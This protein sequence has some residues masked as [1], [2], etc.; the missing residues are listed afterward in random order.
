MPRPYTLEI[1]R[2]Y[3]F[4]NPED[5]PE[6]YHDR[7]KRLRVGYSF[8]YEFP[9][10]TESDIRDHLMSVFNVSRVKAY[11]DI[12]LIKILLGDIKNPG[13][14]WIRYQVNAMLDAAYNQALK[15]N[16]SKAMTLAAT[17]KGKLNMLHL[18][19]AEPVPFDEI[20]PQQ[21]EPTDDPT[22]LGLK[23]D[24]DIREKKRKMLEKYMDDIEIVDVP[25]DEMVKDGNE[26]E[27]EDLL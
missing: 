14:E 11:D 10:K 1:Y 20:V 25:Y 6:T 19:D 13:K 12:N 21:F 9:T 15:D 26:G 23:K 2:K 22:P 27:E 18:P 17:A 8:W 4:S 5:I 3:L 16:D 24:P 7:V